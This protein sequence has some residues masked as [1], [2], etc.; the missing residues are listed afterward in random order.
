MA[1]TAPPGESASPDE[2]RRPVPLRSTISGIPYDPVYSPA[3]TPIDYER[4]LGD[5][6]EYPY[7]RGVYRTMYR[8][9]L[10]TMRQFA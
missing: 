9:R 2:P 1:T 4:D 7:T 6:G 8:G 3:T 5:P 10:W